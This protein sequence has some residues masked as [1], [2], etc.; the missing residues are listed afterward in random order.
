MKHD[1]GSSQINQSEGIDFGETICDLTSAR[2]CP[3]PRNATRVVQLAT[4]IF[5]SVMA[6]SSEAQAP[7]AAKKRARR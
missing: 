2:G 1:N 7:S 5:D 4:L 3:K 6:E